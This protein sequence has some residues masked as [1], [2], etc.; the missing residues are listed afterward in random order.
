MM[1][2]QSNSRGGAPSTAEIISVGNFLCNP[3]QANNYFW[4]FAQPIMIPTTTPTPND[5]VIVSTGCLL[6][7]S[8]VSSMSSSAT[9]PLRL[10]A[11][12]RIRTLSSRR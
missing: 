4:P 7:R 12:L 5:I 6:I 11:R 8:V 10:T 9:S 3:C 2:P 1:E